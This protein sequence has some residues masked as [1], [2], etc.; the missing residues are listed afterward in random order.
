[1]VQ[2]QASIEPVLVQYRASI[3]PVLVQYRASNGPIPGQYWSNTSQVLS[4]L[5]WIGIAPV[6]AQYW[7][8]GVWR[9]LG[10]YWPSKEPVP[11]QYWPNCDGPVLGQYWASTGQNMLRQTTPL[12][13]FS[14]IYQA[15]FVFF[16]CQ[17]LL[18]IYK[19][20]YIRYKSDKSRGIELS[21]EVAYYHSVPTRKL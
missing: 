19:Y 16:S 3:E 15:N 11:A 7:P 17:M 9:V 1:M 4:P 18:R 20:T 10:Q 2:Y 13:L 12:L 21:K 5:C 8:I 6:P 14:R